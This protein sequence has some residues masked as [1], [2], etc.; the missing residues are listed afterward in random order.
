MSNN[1]QKF[2]CYL[3]VALSRF[4][5]AFS[6]FLNQFSF[7]DKDAGATSQSSI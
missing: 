7:I 2:V 5:N 4:R 6:Q 1:W 3:I